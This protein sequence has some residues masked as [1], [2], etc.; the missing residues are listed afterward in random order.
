EMHGLSS[1]TWGKL[2]AGAKLGAVEAVFPRLELGQLKSTG[3]TPFDTKKEPVRKH[4][5]AKPEQEAARISLEE[6]ARVEMRVGCVLSAER[7]PKSSKLLKIK[8]DIGYEER[9]VVAGIGKAY[10]PDELVGKVVVVVT[11]LQ[12]AKLMG[13][14]SNGMIVAAS[15]DGKPV[16]ATFDGDVTLGARL[17]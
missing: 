16:L 15:V 3:E 5:P 10:E 2:E 9:Q 13:V 8:V 4:S 6:F 17:T 12:K 11:N 14:E 7:V 1:L